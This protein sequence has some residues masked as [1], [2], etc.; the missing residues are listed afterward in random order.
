M[1][2]KPKRGRPALGKVKLTCRITPETRA[3]LG[4]RPGEKIDAAFDDAIGRDAASGALDAAADA[5][6]DAG[7]LRPADELLG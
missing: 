3:K 1:N 7:D 2:E 5:I 6:I 4:D